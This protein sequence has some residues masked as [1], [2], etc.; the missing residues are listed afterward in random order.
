MSKAAKRQR[1]KERRA[2]RIRIEEQLV[3]RRKM[4]RTGLIFALLIAPLIVAFVVVRLT[5]DNKKN[6]KEVAGCVSPKTR[7]KDSP[8]LEVDTNSIYSVSIETSEGV[9]TADLDTCTQLWGANNFIVLARKGFY[10]GTTF[11]RAAKDFVIQG[12]DPKGDGSGGPGYTFISELPANGYAVGDLAYAK[13]GDAPAGSAGSQFFVITAEKGV[14]ETFN[15]Q[16]YQYGQ[17]GKLT[18][19][20]DVAKKIEA[21]APPEGDGKPTKEV[22]ISKVTVSKPSPRTTTSSTASTTTTAPTPSSSAAQ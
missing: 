19:G 18:G 6:Q 3:R 10:D 15:K 17:F 16:P 12:G 11:H 8:K 20:L 13:T 21:L 1:Q 7:P 14:T 2:E 22:K 4:I 9:M 5:Q